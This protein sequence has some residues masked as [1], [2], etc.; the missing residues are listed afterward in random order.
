M[1]HS[2]R[3][4]DVGALL[5]LHLHP[6]DSYGAMAEALGAG[7][8]SVH[9]SV[10]RLVRSGL[11]SEVG[12]LGVRAA[13][14]PAREFLQFG[15]PYAFPADTVPKARGIPTGFSAPALRRDGPAADVLLVWPSRLGDSVGVGVH[16]LVPAAPD[17]SFRDPSLYRL[18]ALVDALRMGDAREREI[19]RALIAESMVASFAT[20]NGSNP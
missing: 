2:L 13:L 3:P 12:R 14:G 17:I 5:H 9:A 6:G 19:A 8:S 20:S 10:G 4:L 11:A 15:V 7:K 1:K 16:P 18:L